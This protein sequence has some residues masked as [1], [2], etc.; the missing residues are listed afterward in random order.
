MAARG[1][2]DVDWPRLQTM[3]EV[4]DVPIDT[5]SADTRAE[6]AAKLLLTCGQRAT[7]H[8]FDL[9]KSYTAS[10]GKKLLVHL[11]Y[12]M[13]QLRKVLAGAPRD[14][15]CVIEH[16]REHDFAWVDCLEQ[17]LENYEHF[18]CD[19]ENYLKRYYIGH[20][21]PAGNH[22]CAYR[23]KET[24]VAWLNPKPPAYRHK[25]AQADSPT[26]IRDPL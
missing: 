22:F 23:M 1:A 24:V 16:L 26:T 3:G 18:D 21:S 25:D 9:A 4:L 15:S 12:S 6:S 2:A 10:A 17:H 13:N 7:N 11:P 14:D 5:E 8:T 19:I 20:Y